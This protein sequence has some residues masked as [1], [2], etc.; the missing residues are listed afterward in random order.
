MPLYTRYHQPRFD[1][2]LQATAS[3]L[4]ETGDIVRAFKATTGRY[5]RSHRL[6][7]FQ[8]Q[9]GLYEHELTSD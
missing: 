8:W 6:P 1:N 7:G 2:W 9:R 4:V 5:V 3:S